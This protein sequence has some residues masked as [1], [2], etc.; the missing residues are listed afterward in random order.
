MIRVVDGLIE[1]GKWWLKDIEFYGDFDKNCYG[2]FWYNSD[3]LYHWICI[4]LKNVQIP[5]SGQLILLY[6]MKDSEKIYKGTLNVFESTEKLE[7][8]LDGKVCESARQLV[9][10]AK[11]KRPMEIGCP[12]GFRDIFYEDG[13]YLFKPKDISGFSLTKSAK[14]T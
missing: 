12:E 7:E 6:H 2:E 10:A 3:G 4:E 11:E 5:E 9:E 8:W 13:G 14:K 1:E